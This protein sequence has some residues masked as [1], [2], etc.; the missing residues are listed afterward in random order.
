M[1]KEKESR[2]LKVALIQLRPGL[3]VSENLREVVRS[4]EDGGRQGA[5]LAVIPENAL[6]IGTNAQMRAAAVTIDGPEITVVREAAA[7]AGVAVV[8]GGFKQRSE[9]PLLQN[10]ALVIRS[11]GSLQGSYDKIHL[12]NAVVAGQS[13]R[14]S[15][16]ESSGEDLVIVEI[17]GVKVGLSIC[18]DIRFPEMFRQLARAGAEVILI[19]SAFTQTTG[20]AHWEVLVRARAIENEAYVVASATIT[21]ND[22]AESGFA[23]YGH[24]LVVDPWGK[25]LANLGTAPYAVQVLELD[26]EHVAE[27]R[28]RLPV[29]HVGNPAV[30][31]KTPLL[32]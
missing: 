31:Q 9:A 11:D 4:I 14:A 26:L 21:S 18:F 3:D 20:E 29:L 7:K 27:V 12:F 24:S 2:N 5:D 22:A 19:P 23:T 17:A 16:V 8:L 15:D 6:C 28:S 30:Y 1:S 10:T 25:V 32:I 13:F